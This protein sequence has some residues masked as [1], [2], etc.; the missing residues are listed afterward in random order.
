MKRLSNIFCFSSLRA[1]IIA[2]IMLSSVAV[3][4]LSTTFFTSYGIKKMESA[5]TKEMSTIVDMAA[6]RNAAALTFNNQDFS[7]ESLSTFNEVDNVSLACLNDKNGRVFASYSRSGSSKCTERVPNNSGIFKE[8]T[9][10]YDNYF[11]ITKNI[12]SGGDLVG[13][14]SIQAT[15]AKIDSYIFDQ[16]L[17]AATIMGLI[18]V[19]S[20]FLSL[21]LHKIISNPILEVIEIAQNVSKVDDFSVR[22]PDTQY[23]ELSTLLGAFNHILNQREELHQITIRDHKTAVRAY[24]GSKYNLDSA[25]KRLKKTDNAMSFVS[26]VLQEKLLG[27]NVENYLPYVSDLDKSVTNYRTQMHS[28]QDLSAL[29]ERTLNEEKQSLFISAALEQFV[30]LWSETKDGYKI[31]FS[32]NISDEGEACL[33]IEPF[34]ES[35]KIIF[36]LVSEVYSGSKKD[37]KFAIKL[38]GK[39][40]IST[41]V[42]FTVNFDSFSNEEGNTEEEIIG[43]I[44]FCLDCVKYLSIVNNVS[45]QFLP[46]YS[47]DRP[48][49]KVVMV[50]NEEAK[51]SANIIGFDEAKKLRSQKN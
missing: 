30:S 7:R 28:F 21:R 46:L 27:N 14:L 50:I 51:K 48:S 41:T 20:Y 13:S 1:K 37:F 34:Y 32:N 10:F 39:S 31:E 18:L 33:Y 38:D 15:T 24:Y 19:L 6:R 29:Y 49:F 47:N 22:A 25:L 23:K 40:E 12:F 4:A 9:K 45:V 26:T 8:E 42:T 43:Q 11:T 35:L 16:L 5:I 17:A 36:G 3:I 44:Q 2:A